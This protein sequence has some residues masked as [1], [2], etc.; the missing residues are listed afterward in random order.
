MAHEEAQ[1]KSTEVDSMVTRAG[2]RIP[3]SAS[4]QLDAILAAREAQG[5][6]L[7]PL[8]NTPMSELSDDELAEVIRKVEV[9]LLALHDEELGEQLATLAY[10]IANPSR[11]VPPLWGVPHPRLTAARQAGV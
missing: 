5:E 10:L 6:I 11:T 1:P 8:A 7:D 4:E 2:V 9:D 3:K